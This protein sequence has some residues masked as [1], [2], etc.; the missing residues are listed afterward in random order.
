MKWSIFYSDRVLHG[1]SWYDWIL[2]TPDRDVQV[3]VL[4]EPP[5]LRNGVPYRPWAGVDDRQLWTGLD[6][7]D[8]FG[9]RWRKHGRLLV[10]EDY[11]RIW[12][13]AA[14]GSRNT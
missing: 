4:W 13:V 10:D 14:Y 2:G 7:Y 8:P 1:D 6:H 3:V 11:H 9:Y 5:P 12:K